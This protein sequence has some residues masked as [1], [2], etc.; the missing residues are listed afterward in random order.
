MGYS[1]HVP[2]STAPRPRL[3]R[4]LLYVPGSN[5]KA[6]AKAPGLGADGLILDLED[7]VL[8][9]EKGSARAAV[10][11][12]VQGTDFGYR[13]VVV[14][15]NGLHT[16]WGL[17]GLP[18]LASSRADA[19]LLPKV[20]DPRALLHA[21][22]ELERARA[23]DSLKVWAM[24]ETPRGVLAMEAIARCTPRLQV[25]VMGTA[26]LTQALRAPEQAGRAALLPALAHC[27]LAARAAGLDILDGVFT[28]LSDAPGFSA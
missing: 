21:C 18:T 16:E 11:A 6:L 24:G 1:L 23:P 25:L 19:I 28:R 10:L 4:S 20:E 27:L 3:R 17:A 5:A 13:E 14:R 15:I 7:S 2:M 8:P 26:D 12:A 22:A 9:A